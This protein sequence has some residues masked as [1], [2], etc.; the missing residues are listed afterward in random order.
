MMCGWRLCCCCA[1]KTRQSY[2]DLWL[3]LKPH[4]RS[5]VMLVTQHYED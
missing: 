3:S 1:R 2:L 5:G 4:V